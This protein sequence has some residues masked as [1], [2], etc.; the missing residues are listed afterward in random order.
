MEIFLGPGSGL[1]W[2]ILL[3]VIGAMAVYLTP[4]KAARWVALV[5]TAVVLAL[6]L[7]ITYLVATSPVG[8][9]SLSQLPYAINIPWI[10]VKAGSIQLTIKYFL[11]VDGLCLPLVFLNALLTL[12]AV[13]GGWEKTRV[14]D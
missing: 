4:V 7:Y 6:T 8:F 14:K 1:T 10:H 3:P 9:G 13:I 5:T 11:C 2:I 12:L